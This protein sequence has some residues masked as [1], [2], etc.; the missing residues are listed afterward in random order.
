MRTPPE[1]TPDQQRT[2]DH[3]AALRQ[4]TPDAVRAWAATYDVPLLHAEDDDLLLLSIH[5]ARVELLRGAAKRTSQQWLHANRAR[6][7]A[8]RGGAP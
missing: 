7:L 1:R 5:A 4:G 6:I 3:M 8:A 2:H